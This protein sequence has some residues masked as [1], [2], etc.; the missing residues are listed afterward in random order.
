[1][2]EPHSSCG[3]CGAR[4]APWEK[5][6]CS[7]DGPMRTSAAELLYATACVATAPMHVRD[8]VRIVERDYGCVLRESVANAILAPDL[9]FCWA[10][11][12][13]YCLYRHGPLPGPRTLEAAA[14]LVLYAAREP[15]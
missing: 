10:G 2:N 7:C 15:L 4:F 5:W 9:R 11:K 8:F 13:L 6:R 1:M 3:R 12:G 14:R